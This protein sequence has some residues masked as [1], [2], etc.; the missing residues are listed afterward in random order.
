MVLLGGGVARRPVLQQNALLLLLRV[1]EC[2][3]AAALN[4]SAAD[5]H[6]GV[7]ATGR[8]ATA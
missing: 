7:H 3:A 6:Q 5:S 2:D 8:E 4:G 1:E